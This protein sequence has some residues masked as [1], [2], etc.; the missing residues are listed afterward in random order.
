MVLE[1]YIPAPNEEIP[2]IIHGAAPGADTLAGA[3][4]QDLDFLVEAFP[5]DWER[6]GRD[7][8]PIRNRAML[9]TKPDL[10]IAFKGGR[11]TE[12]CVR[13]A[14]KLGITVRREP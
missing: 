1:E 10:V 5:A 6:H 14:K 9:D 8:G 11:G 4:A 7:A 3:T 2:T 13:Q 12:N